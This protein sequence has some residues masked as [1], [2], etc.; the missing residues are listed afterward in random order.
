MPHSGIENLGADKLSALIRDPQSLRW[1]LGSRMSA[2]DERK[3]SDADLKDL[4]V[5]LHYMAGRKASPGAGS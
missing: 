2:I 3:L 4:L 1:W 5:Y